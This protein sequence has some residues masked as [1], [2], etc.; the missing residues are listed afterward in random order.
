MCDEGINGESK[1]IPKILIVK[2][3]KL[4][5]HPIQ[6]SNLFELQS[7][8]SNLGKITAKFS[9]VGNQGGYVPET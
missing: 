2:L 3:V 6:L 7:V 1:I 4:L 9:N 5:M 8:I